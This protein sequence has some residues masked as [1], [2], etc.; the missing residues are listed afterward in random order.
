MEA[1]MENNGKQALDGSLRHGDLDFRYGMHVQ[2]WPKALEVEGWSE[3]LCLRI[4]ETQEHTLRVAEMTVALAGMT[5]IPES[6]VTYVR[7]G[8]LLHD[9]GKLGIPDSILLKPGRLS[10]GE[11]DTMRKHPDYAYDLIYPIEYFRPCLSIPYSHHERWDGTGYPQG[12]KGEEIPLPARLFAIVDV[13]ETLSSNRVYRQAWPQDRVM[14]YIQHQSGTHFDPGV[15]EL[16]LYAVSKKIYP[17]GDEY[18]AQ[19]PLAW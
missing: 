13:W 3:S 14:D 8:A 19:L 15:V 16:F 10:R 17:M 4:K 1:E 2:S 18:S 12:L 6:A 11:W 5:T 7:F 9:I